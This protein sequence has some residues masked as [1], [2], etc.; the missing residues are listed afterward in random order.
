MLVC[1]VIGMWDEW[2]ILKKMEN[3]GRRAINDDGKP[4]R[5]I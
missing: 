2:R 1:I 3:V 5:K 4:S